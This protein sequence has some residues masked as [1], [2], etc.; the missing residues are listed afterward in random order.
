MNSSE[1][2][3]CPF[4]FKLVLRLRFVHTKL[5]MYCIKFSSC[6]KKNSIILLRHITRNKIKHLFNPIP[7]GVLGKHY[8]LGGGAIC[9]PPLLIPCL[10]SKYDKYDKWYIIGKLLCSTF[11]IYLYIFKKPLTMP[12]QMCKKF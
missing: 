12:F 6:T 10:M 4:K 9:P 5:R 2:W 11:R 7:D 8:T 1:S 3:S